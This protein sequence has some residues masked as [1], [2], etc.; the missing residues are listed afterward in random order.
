MSEA[1]IVSG[2]MTTIKAMSEFADADVVDSDWSVLDQP[3]VNAP[4][5]IF[6]PSDEFD[7]RQ[8][9]MSPETDWII[10]AALVEPFT[11]WSTTLVNFRTRRQAI[12]DK[13]NTEDS[14]FRGPSSTTNSDVRRVR[15]GSVI[16]PYYDP[17]LTEEEVK[18][19]VPIYLYQIIL[20]EVHEW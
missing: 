4:Y 18:E 20:F 9:T 5:V 6:T 11:E 10:P 19:A 7:G 1:S 8:D 16:E 12:L 15:S 3:T 14:A 13:I 2:L 17:W